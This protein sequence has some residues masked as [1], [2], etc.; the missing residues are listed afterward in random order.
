M[1]TLILWVYFNAHN[2]LVLRKEEAIR[3]RRRFDVQPDSSPS[4]LTTRI[5]CFLSCDS[6]SL[7]CWLQHT[8]LKLTLLLSSSVGRPAVTTC[9]MSPRCHRPHLETAN[10]HQLA[11]LKLTGPFTFHLPCFTRK[12]NCV[13]VCGY[14]VKSFQAVIMFKFRLSVSERHITCDHNVSASSLSASC[15]W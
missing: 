12:S 10:K 13:W 3:G 11:S 8:R 4:S 2:T 1:S 6:Q 14:F 9:V 15:H 7:P 5:W